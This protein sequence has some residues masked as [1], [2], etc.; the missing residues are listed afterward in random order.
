MVSLFLFLAAM[1]L[2]QE[3]QT[4]TT[5]DEAQ[6]QI[7]IENFARGAD[8][9]NTTLIATS[10]H[11]EAQQYFVGQDGLVR[12]SR[13]DYFNMLEQK[14]IGG[15]KRN[16]EISSITVNENLAVASAAMWNDGVRFENYFSLM[17]IGGTWQIVSVVLRMEVG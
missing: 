11:P 7:A 16:L 13:T 9:Q 4:L 5:G 17:K 1:M 14:K 8:A 15:Q 12:L 2:P 3:T 10:L 6:I